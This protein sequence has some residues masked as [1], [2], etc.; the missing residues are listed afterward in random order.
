MREKLTPRRKDILNFISEFLEE[1][2]YPPSVREIGEAVGFASASSVHAHLSVLA[3]DGYILKDP[4][5]TRAIKVVLDPDDPDPEI[6]GLRNIPLVGSVAAGT[7]VLAQENIDEI[8]AIPESLGG[9]G[10]LFALRVRGDSMIERGILDG[11]IVVTRSQPDAEIG[12]L[13]V[14]GIPDDLATVKVFKRK[15]SKI[16]LE[17]ANPDFKPIV[18]P[19]SEVSIYGKV[20]SLLRRF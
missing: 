8:I 10:E 17:P 14:A 19:S 5:K 4:V 18:L 3:R 13:V 12:D 6:P 16:I 11:D 1:K 9:S 20:I 15:G 7:G 2:G